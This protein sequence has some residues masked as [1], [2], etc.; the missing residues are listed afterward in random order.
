[1]EPK[2]KK[3]KKKRGK[4][5]TKVV[6]ST[7]II[8]YFFSRIFPIIGTSKQKT[9]VAQYGKIEQ[10]IAT[11]GFIARDEKVLMDGDYGEAKY[12]VSEG[13]KV[14]KGQKLAEIHR[15]KLDDKSLEELEIINSRIESI[16]NKQ[17]TPIFQRDVDK[18]DAQISG[19]LQKIQQDIK[20]QDYEKI[21]Q[22]QAEID[23]LANKKKVIIGEDSFAGKNLTELE[24]QKVL[25]EKKL[26]TA[27]ETITSDAPGFAAFGSDG[28]ED[29]L[30]PNSIAYFTSSDL[31]SIKNNYLDSK[32]EKPLDENAMKMIYN[33]EWS[34]ICELTEEE[35]EGLEQGKNI[36]VRIQ[37]DDGNYSASIRKIIEDE[38]KRL[39][40]LD[41]TD[42]FEGL[43]QLRTLEVDIVKN[44][45]EGPMIPNEAIVEIDEGLGVYR[46]NINGIVK[47]VPVKVKGKNREYSIVYEGSFTVKNPDDEESKDV[48]TIKL[49]DEIVLK[50]NKISEGQKIR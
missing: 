45:H 11:T 2:T 25:I 4:H 23:E 19:L 38:D 21:Q 44:L 22:Y 13:E 36:I 3:R 33:Y 6:I 37:G 28:L 16:N 24:E 7:I 20:Q 9:V 5:F 47:W 31:E 39:L 26:N 12:F 46:V 15:E 48:S 1:M 50:G 43:Y 17:E 18:I 34:M 49:Y 32:E 27:L 14:A 35:A 30:T 41:L 8:L 10:V 40:V 29:L 42:V